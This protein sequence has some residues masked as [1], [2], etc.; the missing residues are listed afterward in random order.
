MKTN[1][2]S[3]RHILVTGGL[4]FIGSSLSI[5]LVELG[6][7]VTIIDN[8]LPDHGG[9]LFN[10]EPIRNKVNI[11]FG[12]ILSENVMNYLVQG[13]DFV[14]HLAGQV[15]H[16]LSLSNPYP[17]IDINIKGTAI[18]MEALKKHNRNA[19]V[20][21]TGTRGVYG[22]SVRLPVDENAPTYPKG[23]HEIANLTAEKIVKVYNDIH[24]IRS[25][26]LRLTNIYGP[27]AQMKH[28]HYCVVNWFVR[29]AIDG[30]TIKVFGDGAIVRDFLFVDDCVDAILASAVCKNGL[31]EVMN[32]G[33]DKPTS[34]LELIKTIIDIAGTG[35]WELAPF[36]PERQAQE[37]GDFYSN[38]EKIRRIA[39]W[40]PRVALKDGI[41][42]TVEY[43][44][45]HKKFYW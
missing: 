16:V 36:S 10:I 41:K 32:V 5:K 34:F 4:G 7:R 44:R 24:G 30:E 9:N 43:Y 31:G 11:N 38:I 14:F 40:E 6:A 25:M 42:K 1:A 17:D 45:K 23:I 8:M 35:R 19:I 39:G 29:Q 2:F 18:L 13:K 26:L 33:I 37:P 28:S 27:R 22:A 15:S 20:V 21:Y 3:G 12:D